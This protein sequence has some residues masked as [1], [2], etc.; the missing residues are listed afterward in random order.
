ME[1]EIKIQTRKNLPLIPL[2]AILVARTELTIIFLLDDTNWIE[3]LSKDL[4]RMVVVY[5]L[6]NTT[7]GCRRAV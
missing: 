4:I 5:G 1:I 6:R 2:D 3:I 7:N